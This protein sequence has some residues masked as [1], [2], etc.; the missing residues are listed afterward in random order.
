MSSRYEVLTDEDRAQFLEKG[1]VKL[2]GCFTR[3]AARGAHP[4]HLGPA[5]LSRGRPDD[6]GTPV[7]A[8]GVAPTTS[9]SARSRPKAWQAACELIGGEP[10]GWPPGKPF[11]WTDAFIVN[12]RQEHEGPWTPASPATPGWHVDG[13]WFRHYLDSPEQG[14]LAIVLWSDVVPR[15]RRRRSSPPTRSGRSPASWPTTP[16]ACCPGTHAGTGRDDFRLRRAG[17]AVRRVRRGHRPG[18]RRLPAA[19]VRA[20]RQVA[21]RRCGA[22]VHHQ[23]D[24]VPRPSR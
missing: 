12:L 2:R 20:A 8:H 16:R 24:A 19:P 14:L 11:P 6:L 13:S 15:G 3:E 7:G 1:Y 5:R 23:L 18:R 21:E 4:A 10:S 17:R 22:A 9:T